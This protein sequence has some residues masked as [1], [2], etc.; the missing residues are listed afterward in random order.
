MESIDSLASS[1]LARARGKSFDVSLRAIQA[2]AIGAT[3]RP[4][5]PLG[6]GGGV[7]LCAMER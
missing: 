3:A 7:G 4:A 5:P 6:P 2:R 1:G